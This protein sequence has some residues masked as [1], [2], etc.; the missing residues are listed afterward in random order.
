MRNVLNYSATQGRDFQYMLAFRKTALSIFTYFN[1][2]RPV[3]TNLDLVYR[4]HNQI[5]LDV[6]F[7]YKRNEEFKKLYNSM[8]KNDKNLKSYIQRFGINNKLTHF[9][10]RVLL[11]IISIFKIDL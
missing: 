10:S 11:K 5:E 6:Y 3:K 4:E 1:N 2:L 8:N 7:S 9:F